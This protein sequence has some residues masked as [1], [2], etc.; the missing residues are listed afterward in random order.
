MIELTP[1]PTLRPSVMGRH[2]AVA[3]GHYLA[4][5][6][7]VRIMDAGGNVVDA[8]VAAG[9]CLNVV[10]PDMTNLGGVAPI[11]VRRADGQVT[12]VSGVG[13][14]PRAATLD[15]ILRRGGDISHGILASVVPAALDAWVEALQAFGTTRFADVAAPA[16]ELAERGFPV[17]RFLYDNL[18][19]VAPALSRWP[20]SRAVYLPHRHPPPVGELLIQRDLAATLRLL[21][22]AEGTSAPRAEGLQAVRDRF[23]H[24]DIGPA[25]AAFCQRMGGLLTADDL[26]GFRVKQEPAVHATYR[27]YDVYGCG[28]WCQGPVLLQ[29]LNILE[30]YD[31]AALPH[32]SAE[33][34]H[35][36]LEALKAAFADRHAYYGDPAFVNVPVELLLSK[37]YAARWREHIDPCR[38]SPGMPSPGDSG[39]PG[40]A[41]AVAAPPPKMPSLGGGNADTSYVCVV[42]SNGN[43]FSATPSDGVLDAP[44]VPK[45]G[46]II[47]ARGSQSWLDPSHPAC[48]APGKRPR[49]TP[50]PALVA[51]SDGF[52]LPFGTPGHDVQPQAMLQVL[53]NLIEYEMDPQQAV[54]AAR[55]ASYSFPASTPPH[56]YEPGLVRAEA[57]IPSAVR[58]A[59]EALGHRLQVWPDWTPKAGGVCA[60]LHDPGLGIVVAAADPRRLSYAIG[61]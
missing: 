39:R 41:V 23:Y 20:S 48:L 8:G 5:L 38:A 46:F 51:R 12:T 18:A 36:I 47:S 57:R 56:R 34:L 25:L 29:A 19:A 7:A 35:L 4:S 31:V 45:L 13:H 1:L 60:A 26:A 54:E 14:W 61:W 9:L 22:E 21:V 43:A 58:T 37:E 2:Y 11:V 27:S 32:N 6:A 50:S 44:I 16:I 33:S 15:E 30:G 53:V 55:V 59:L 24:G 10:Q 42:D 49:I 3:T 28:P 17:N 40:T 52:V